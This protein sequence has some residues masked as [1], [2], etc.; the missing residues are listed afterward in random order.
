M[1]ETLRIEH[2]LKNV[3]QGLLHHSVADSGDAKQPLSTII[4]GNLNP[5]DWL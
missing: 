5:T 4:R 2:R 1:D 3:Q